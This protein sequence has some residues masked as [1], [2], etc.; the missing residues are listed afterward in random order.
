MVECVKIKVMILKNLDNNRFGTNCYLL[1]DEDS[2]EAVLFDAAGDL[3]PQIT[4]ALKEYDAK[5][6]YLLITHGHLDH[7]EGAK[8]IEDNFNVPV[9]AGVNEELL[10]SN[11]PAQSAFMGVENI[12][13]P[14]FLLKV[15]EN[16]P[17]S[18]GE[19]KIKPIHTPGHT[20]GGVC[21]LVDGMLISGDT[22]F[23]EEIGRCDLVGGDFSQ[24]GKSIKEKLFALADETV[25]YPGHGMATTIAHEKEYNAYFGTRATL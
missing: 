15:D 18:I 6:K 1:I 2:K 23:Y 19:H 11:L 8:A 21:Y 12:S 9:F 7:I 16:F 17:L 25:V 14:N 4:S 13:A 3:T 22:L 10:L 5:L 20:L 24:I